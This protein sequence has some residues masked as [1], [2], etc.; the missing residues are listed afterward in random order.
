MG[1]KSKALKAKFADE[2]SELNELRLSS[3]RKNLAN[4]SVK[5]ETLKATYKN[6]L[7]A[8]NTLIDDIAEAGDDPALYGDDTKVVD[9]YRRVDRFSSGR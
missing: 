4:A 7:K 1:K 5:A 3:N 9:L 2:V 8:L 6:Q